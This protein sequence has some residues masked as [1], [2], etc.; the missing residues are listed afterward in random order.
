MLSPISFSCRVCKTDT[1]STL[2]TFADLPLPDCAQ[3]ELSGNLM[4]LTLGFCAGCS[5]V[6]RIG[7]SDLSNYYEGFTYTVGDSPFVTR[8]VQALAQNIVDRFA[9][10]QTNTPPRVL[11]I[12]CNTGTQ[13]RAFAELGCDVVG[14]EPSKS[15]A[16]V[17]AMSGF[18]ILNVAF[19]NNIADQLLRTYGLFDIVV[20]TFTLD[21]VDDPLGF[22]SGI[23]RLLQPEYG[24][25]VLEVHDLQI[26]YSQREIALFDREHSIFPDKDSL[27]CLLNRAG[28]EGFETNFLP[29]MVRRENSLLVLA[30]HSTTNE[31]PSRQTTSE[32]KFIEHLTEF[33]ALN[34]SLGNLSNYLSECSNKG[35]RV[36]GYGAGYRGIMYCSQIANAEVFSYFVDGNDA[37]DGTRLPKSGVDV[38]SPNHLRVDPV[39]KI[40]VFSH[41]YFDEIKAKCLSLGYPE[42]SIISLPGILS[43][44]VRPLTGNV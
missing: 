32:S 13:L 43:R 31:P 24:I 37:L 36:A 17:A 9:S 35:I 34:T 25:L 1:V 8:F 14:V 39:D 10:L 2:G 3:P 28:F 22:L 21:Q 26:T 5:M 41:G 40:V 12:G 6:Q 7:D 11:D 19:D 42:V 29:E 4:D 38:Y 23:K 30:K 27:E 15:L 16:T 33:S 44:D 20:S 18:P